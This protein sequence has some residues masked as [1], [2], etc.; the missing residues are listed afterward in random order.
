MPP[1]QRCCHAAAVSETSEPFP[2]E[3]SEDS[4]SGSISA[5]P[6]LSRRSHGDPAHR[7]VSGSIAA[8]SDAHEQFVASRLGLADQ[9]RSEAATQLD[10]ARISEGLVG[11]SVGATAPAAPAAASGTG[12]R[13]ARPAAA[14]ALPGSRPAAASTDLR[15]ETWYEFL[16]GE[17]SAIPVQLSRSDLLSASARD[18]ER[19]LMK[20]GTID[21]W[22][23]LRD[24]QPVLASPRAGSATNLLARG[25][26]RRVDAP[27]PDV[28]DGAQPRGPPQLVAS[29]P[30][31]VVHGLS[32]KADPK[33]GGLTGLPQQWRD[34]LP[35][36]CALDTQAEEEVMWRA[37]R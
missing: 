26:L 35:E 11:F 13:C 1:P 19:L 22:T 31:N 20:P 17:M 37:R 14:S 24:V 27:T 30:T 9:R 7:S 5:G 25:S 10:M 3:L 23:T 16:S 15:A 21:E 28:S 32:V 6:A 12:A 8:A 34:L 4:N 18:G 2:A 36:G 33:T 29:S